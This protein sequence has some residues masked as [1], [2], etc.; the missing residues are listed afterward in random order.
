MAK[1]RNTIGDT[2]GDKVFLA[3][4]M[5]VS[6]LI[7]CIVIYPL[8]YVLSASFS[9]GD[10]VMNGRVYLFPVEP[11]VEGYKMVFEDQNIL[12]GFKNSL[13]YTFLGTMINMVMT[14]LIA[15]PLSRKKLPG[16]QAIMFI[17][18]FT[19][20]FSG[21]LIP[22]FLVVEKLKMVDTVW[23]MVVPTAIST[24]NLIIMKT[25]FENSIPEEL[26][27][28]AALDGCNNFRFLLSIVLPLSKPILAV[29]VLY[30]AVGHWNQ[31]FNALI[32]L[33]SNERISLQL[34]LRNI[35]LANQI[36]SGGSDSGGF[37]EVAK[38]GLTVK[39]AVIIVSSIPV[40][41]LYPFI[42]KYFVK[43]V[44]IGA[45]KG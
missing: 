6:T 33:R 41:I 18:T 23:A 25:Y 8:L 38:V 19:M 10:A 9:S 32:Y 39:Y 17:V 29:L 21:G 1:Y 14:T 34:A 31:Y 40:M 20:F 27:E 45:I 16:R 43:G 22:T 28:S 37:G 2:S 24:F 12:T 7:L 11:S 36:S 13:I 26:G 42:Q 35:L 5:V 44:M 3:G 30:Y 15:F 4:V